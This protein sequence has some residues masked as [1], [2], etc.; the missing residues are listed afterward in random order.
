MKITVSQDKL[1][2][3][4]N[5]VS[6][7]AM[8]AKATLPILSNV[9]I[10]A[11]DKK[12][13]LTT[14]NLDMAV[15]N[16]VPVID[17]ENGA[18]TVPAR[19]LAEFVGNLPRGEKIK[20]E[21]EG[22][23]VKISS[24]RYSSTI[25]GTLADEFPE[26]PELDEEKS[27]S[28]KMGIDEFKLGIS[29]VIVAASGDTTRPALTGVYFNTAD[30]VLYVA[31]TDGYR[32]AERK[33]INKVE[34]QI[35]VI[36]PAATLQEVMRSITDDISEVELVFEENQVRFRLGETEITS[37][38]IDGTFPDYRQLI[39]KDNDIQVTLDRSELLRITKMSEIVSRE[40]SRAISCET[41]ADKGIFSVSS[42]ANEV[43]ENKSEIEVAVDKSGVIK[44]DSRFLMDALNVL[45]EDNIVFSFSEK[46][47]PVV[48]TNEKST[49]YTHIVM[50]L[51]V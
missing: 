1:A 23:K 7:V 50:P 32:L 43:G 45:E 2:K 30:G 28:Y 31:A 27:V 16:Y 6:K 47:A 29:E 46:V 34:D 15:V 24:G 44:L 38:L 33:L 37:K 35:M 12:V 42:I 26:L 19:L 5:I 49:D 21:A 13:S 4:L 3:A 20:I 17:A 9:L 36:V 25:N 40:S 18:V 8:G 39:P 11:D 51:N 14:T 22:A 10:R 41:D 48:L